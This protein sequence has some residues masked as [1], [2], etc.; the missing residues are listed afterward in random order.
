[1]SVIV[2][3][4]LFLIYSNP[5]SGQESPVQTADDSESEVNRIIKLSDVCTCSEIR[6]NA[7]NHNNIVLNILCSTLDNTNSF[8]DLDKI[9][10]PPNPHNLKITT[11]F[12]GLGI[13]TLAKLPPHPQV[14]SLYFDDNT[15]SNYWPEP[16]IG[17]PNLKV[18]SFYKNDLN[19]VRHDLF[20]RIETLEE[21]D[22]SYNKLAALGPDIFILV[23]QLKRLN[24]QSN[25]LTEMP[26]ITLNRL[27]ALEELDLSRNSIS[28]E[29]TLRSDGEAFKGLKRVFLGNNKINYISKYSFA[30]DNNIELLDLSYNQIGTI[31][32]FAIAK[33]GNLQELNLANNNIAFVF[34]L[35][36]S[37]QI[38]IMKYNS[39][40]QWPQ[41]PVGIKL[42]DLS[43][44][45]LSDI[46]DD[47]S[48]DFQNLEILDISGNQISD[49]NIQKKMPSLLNLD[50]AYNMIVDIPRTLNSE[51]FPNLKTLRLDGNPIRSI[52]F[53]NII[54]LKTLLMNDLESLTVV[55]DKSFSN[56]MGR[57]DIVMNGQ[58]TTVVGS[59]CFSL[60]L[61]NCKSLQEIRTGAFDGTSLCMLDIS[62]NNLT[63]IPR[64]LLDWSS[65]S[66]GV[67]LQMNP[68]H[69]NCSLEWMLDELLARMY[70]K[71]PTLL[72]D[73]RCGS[74]QGF[75]G[76]RL[77]H[78]YNWTEEP[79]CND[80]YQRSG[81]HD[82][83]MVEASAEEY[84]PKVTT[85]T[86]VLSVSII[87]SLF[88]A[89]A[90]IV[91]LVK[92]RQKIK[93]QQ[94]TKHRKRQKASDIKYFNGIDKEQMYPM[95]KA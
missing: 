29:L 65:V 73:M 37:V 39:L 78:W 62:K 88:V 16:L 11:H 57:E 41:F 95:N 14:E 18:L 38:V 84:F 75:K 47:D 77:V 19:I 94:A 48:S 53:K 21:L 61:S 4:M 45:R 69:C 20:A 23:P 25:L 40:Y 67:N 55:E 27:A 33:C 50:L 59:R 35:P 3:I 26:I 1:M 31:D 82:T 12:Q 66:E 10:W 43:N 22:L 15:I 83:F 92:T 52:Y 70:D 86:I 85:M 44:N 13:T 24:L 64:D 56:V 36:R 80:V 81:P 76:L 71:Y 5:I 34:E 74:P 93:M 17:V 72:L 91:Y 32:E 79:L 54:A 60:Y 63:N 58:E 8:E 68:W 9:E 2:Y 30:S 28:G 46:Y 49:L 51:I 6:D 90:L 87:V 42:I 7:G 89:I